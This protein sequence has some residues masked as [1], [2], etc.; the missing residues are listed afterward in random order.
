LLTGNQACFQEPVHH[1][2]N[3]LVD[4]LAARWGR[5]TPQVLM[6]PEN[7]RVKTISAAAADATRD[8]GETL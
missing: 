8:D 1:E 5:G 4:T 3:D 7:I 6:L 2:F